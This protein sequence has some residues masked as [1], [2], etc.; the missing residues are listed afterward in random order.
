MIHR[1]HWIMAFLTHCSRKRKERRTGKEKAT[2][3]NAILFPVSSRSMSLI[4]LLF[5][6]FYFFSTTPSHVLS[7]SFRHLL[8]HAFLISHPPLITTTREGRKNHSKRSE[9]RSP[10]S[11]SQSHSASNTTGEDGE[12]G[13]RK[14]VQKARSLVPPHAIIS[15]RRQKRSSRDKGREKVEKGS[16]KPDVACAC[17]TCS[18]P[19]T[20]T[21]VVVGNDDESGCCCITEQERNETN[22]CSCLRFICEPGPST[23]AAAG[24]SCV[25][26][27]FPGHTLPRLA[28]YLAI[29]IHFSPASRFSFSLLSCPSPSSYILMLR[30]HAL[31]F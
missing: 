14:T 29:A 31:T 9:N 12:Y 18:R 10:C 24:K 20:T 4:V 19:R 7:S 15:M 22:A 3:K 16:R 2:L 17:Q 25:S 28:P 11:V 8:C 26:M 13:G 5:C 23:T 1:I 21:A 6:L 27:H 30:T